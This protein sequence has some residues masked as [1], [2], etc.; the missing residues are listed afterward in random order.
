MV[1]AQSIS[2]AD[3][4]NLMAL[5]QSS[6]KAEEDSDDMGAPSAAAYESKS[7]GIIR[8]KLMGPSFIAIYH[9]L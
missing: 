1:D 8:V 3:G 4:S 5:V 6:A 9:N 7:G 2:S